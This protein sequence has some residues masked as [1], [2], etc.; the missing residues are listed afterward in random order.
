MIITVKLSDAHLVQGEKV[1][2]DHRTGRACVKVSA[3]EKIVGDYVP[4]L[5][6]GKDETI[7]PFE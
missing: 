1:W 5:F 3:G 7:L 2:H 4:S 6:D